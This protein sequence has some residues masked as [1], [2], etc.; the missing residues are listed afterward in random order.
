MSD[1]IFRMSKVNKLPETFTPNHLYVVKKSDT[2]GEMYL[3]DKEG[4]MVYPLNYK[5]EPQMTHKSDL[6]I[7]F[8]SMVKITNYDSFINYKI[9][10]ENCTARRVGDTIYVKPVTGSNVFIIVNGKRLRLSDEG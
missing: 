2:R 4:D 9:E 8:E 6:I 10:T 7:G 1:N 3:S 5:Y